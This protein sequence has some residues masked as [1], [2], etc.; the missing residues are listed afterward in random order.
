MATGQGKCHRLSLEMAAFPALV[1]LTVMGTIPALWE[2]EAELLFSLGNLAPSYLRKLKG[3][4]QSLTA[5]FD[6]QYLR[7][8][9]KAAQTWL[10]SQLEFRNSH[11]FCGTVILTSLLPSLWS[12]P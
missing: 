3:L 8:K 9:Q 12:S 6:C 1:L 4:G 10:V 7:T 2:A 11:I 5:G